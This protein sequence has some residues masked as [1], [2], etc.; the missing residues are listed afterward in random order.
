MC[1]RVD[2][3]MSQYEAGGRGGGD[4]WAGRGAAGVGVGDRLSAAL[5]FLRVLLTLPPNGELVVVCPYLYR[6]AG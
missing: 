3:R 2:G 1:E 5:V 6:P 4:G